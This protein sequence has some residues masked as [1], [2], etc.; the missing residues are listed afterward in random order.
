MEI[1][2]AETTESFK[3]PVNPVTGIT[4]TIIIQK[5]YI[6]ICKAVALSR[7]PVGKRLN[8]AFL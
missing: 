7:L 1:M 3:A 4:A 6:I 5:V 2:I 8:P